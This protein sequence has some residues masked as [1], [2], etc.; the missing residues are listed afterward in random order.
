V[1]LQKILALGGSFFR[2]PAAL[3]REVPSELMDAAQYPVILT[4]HSISEGDSPLKVSPSLFTE[5]MEW[6]KANVRVVPLGEIVAALPGRRPLPERAVVLTF[7]DGFRDFY[8]SAAPVL[9]RLRLPATVFLPTGYCGKSNCWPSQPAWVSRE[10][11]LDWK[12]VTE[13]VQDGFKIGAHGINHSDLTTL[14]L[15]EAEQ[16][17]SGSKSQIEE[18]TACQVE[19][20]A[21]PYG[22]WS[23]T[24]RALVLGNYRAACATAA[25]VVEPDADPFALPRADAHYV[26]HPASFRML[27]TT[28]FAA[29]I[30]ARRFIRR[31]RRQPEGFYA[32]I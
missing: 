14:S 20:F 9:R 2:A 11:L 8:S 18:H 17:I 25:G 32:R 3:M 22:R 15:E 5:Q 12:Q 6:L 1:F 21:Y 4:Y 30:A 16:E 27:F 13:L 28:K 24:L 26:R 19:F 7:D 29:Y 23:P 31:M 10:A